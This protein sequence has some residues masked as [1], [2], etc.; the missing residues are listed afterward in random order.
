MRESCLPLQVGREGGREGRRK[1]LERVPKG[2]SYSICPVSNEQV[3]AACK[4]CQWSYP[5]P[6]PA[7]RTVSIYVKKCVMASANGQL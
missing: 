3:P 7:G 2:W 5:W 6:G 4:Q 1:E